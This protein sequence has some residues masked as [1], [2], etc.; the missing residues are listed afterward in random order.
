MISF[1]IP[2]RKNSK[3]VKNKN[4]RAIPYYPNG[5][6][7]L[8]INQLKKLRTLIKKNKPKLFNDIEIVI[9]TN[10][11]KVKKIC[12]NFKWIKIHERNKYLSND[13]SIQELIEIV[14]SVCKGDYILWTHVTSPFFN[15]KKYFNFLIEYFKKGK[16]KNSAFSADIIQKFIYS[17]K[18]GWL[19]HKV[20]KNHWPRTQDLDK[21]FVVNSAAFIAPI[22]VYKK[23]KN[24]LCGNP[25]PVSTGNELDGFD[26][27][28]LKDFMYFKKKLRSNGKAKL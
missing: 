17:L 24:R 25:I 12:K 16:N 5:L 21:I 13:K 2:I 11:E 22:N 14:P 10:C 18:Q 9:S 3:R 27:D 23:F 15:E 4:T 1:F 6:T 26:I 28:N 20:R 7:E 8:K 19:S